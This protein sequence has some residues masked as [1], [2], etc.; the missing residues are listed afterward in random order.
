[1]STPVSTA[2]CPETHDGWFAPDSITRRVF[3]HPGARVFGALREALMAAVGPQSAH[4]IVTNS[5]Y[6][7]DPRG[8]AQRTMHFADAVV[9]GTRSQ[10]EKACAAVRGRHA[11]V[12][13]TDPT[14]GDTYSLAGPFHT[15]DRHLDRR[16]MISGHV[17]IMESFMVAYHAFCQKLS[18]AEQ[19][20]YMLEVAPIAVGLGL[21]PGDVPTTIAGVT[22]FYADLAPALALTPHGAQLFRSLSDPTV[23][24]PKLWPAKPAQ[25]LIVTQT[26]TTIP[27]EFRGLMPMS[28]PRNLDP[29]LR[30]SGRITA[31]ALAAG[32]VRVPLERVV[33]DQLSQQLL[34]DARAAQRRRNQ[35]R[36]A[37]TPR[38]TNHTSSEADTPRCDSAAAAVRAG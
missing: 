36:P 2:T 37:A 4:G 25:A 6:R 31:A 21:E 12:Q 17:I 18:P 13:G 1:M 26:L 7:T 9:F 35:P 23:F 24:N 34:A 38:P 16:L 3:T 8:R 32:P 33:H 5:R 19:D 15:P 30:H 10:A 28:T 11:R 27:D 20:Q 29:I 22:Q 14:T